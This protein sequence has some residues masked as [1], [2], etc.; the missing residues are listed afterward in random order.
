[1]YRLLDCITQEHH[2]GLVA[3]AAFI[4]VVGS[5]LSVHM[6]TRLT[7]WTGKR[8]L[9]QLPL[10]SL[11][12]GATIWSTHFIGMLAYEPSYDHGYEPVLTGVSLVVAV[13]GSLVANL[14]L[15]FARDNVAPVLAGAV[16]GMTVAAMHYTGMRAYLLPGE[17]EWS[18]G[19]VVS[20]VLLGTVLGA[21]S[22]ALIVMRLGGL[23]GRVWPTLV[24]VCAICLMH[25]TGMSAIDIRLDSSFEVP[26]KTISDTAMALLIFAV[27]AVI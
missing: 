26:P 3:V 4:C 1:M 27:T 5:A 8:R 22:Y 17:I 7:E 9:V 20:S 14:G 21:G 11:I 23:P 2:Y 6:S 10:A 19:T 13:L 18:L 25:F 24:M 12:T 16:F 15:A